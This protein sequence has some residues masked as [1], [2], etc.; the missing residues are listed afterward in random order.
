MRDLTRVAVSVFVS[1]LQDFDDVG[2]RDIAYWR[3]SHHR[4]GVSL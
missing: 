3:L 1:R 4:G 2:G